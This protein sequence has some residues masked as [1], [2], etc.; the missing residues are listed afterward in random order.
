MCD[1][2]PPTW[3]DQRALHDLMKQSLCGSTT[4]G[5][6]NGILAREYGALQ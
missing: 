1:A 4:G 2:S 6:S 3:H 5:T